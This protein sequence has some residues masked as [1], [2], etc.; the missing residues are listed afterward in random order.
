[1]PERL[2]RARLGISQQWL[3]RRLSAALDCSLGI[4]HELR[5][6]ATR[7]HV[8]WLIGVMKIFH[9]EP[10][11]FKQPDSTHIGVM[12]LYWLL[13]GFTFSIAIVMAFNIF[14]AYV[15][16]P[17]YAAEG[18]TPQFEDRIY[19]LIAEFF[20][21]ISIVIPHAWTVKWPSLLLR[22]SVIVLA[23]SW[24][25]MVD[26]LAYKRGLSIMRFTPNGF[27]ALLVASMLLATLAIE[28]NRRRG[29]RARCG[30]GGE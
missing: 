28:F 14:T 18:Y 22:V 27:V 7:A 1:M 23:V 19:Q 16:I 2:K 24:I 12:N 26:I 6:Q 3:A 10:E 20:L 9:D 13:R 5:R 17:F 25:V 15:W 29:T 21:F 30:V 8:R 11:K 4:L